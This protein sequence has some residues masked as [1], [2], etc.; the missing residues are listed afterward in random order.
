MR[1][2]IRLLARVK[3]GQ[4]LEAYAPTGLTGI[5][6]H[7]SPRPALITTY[8]EILEKLKAAPETSVYRQ[9][10]EALTKHRLKIVEEI[11]PAGFDEW[12]ERARKRVTQNPKAYEPFRQPDGSYKHVES[13]N[14]G[15]SRAWDGEERTPD[16]TAVTGSEEVIA[17]MNKKLERAQKAEED[18][19]AEW[20]S[21]PAL[22]STQ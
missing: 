19:I 1:S 3:P 7:P 14:S 17:S 8:T 2:S 6:T 15:K 12:L 5:V 20:E 16:L 10:T 18:G 13:Y 9:S 22:D 21:E 11:K 4:F